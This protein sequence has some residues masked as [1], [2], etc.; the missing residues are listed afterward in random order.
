M[1]FLFTATL[2]FRTLYRSG[3]DFVFNDFQDITSLAFNGVAKTT[4]NKS[5][6]KDSNKWMN[7][8]KENFQE[9]LFYKDDNGAF[10]RETITTYRVNED[11]ET[12]TDFASIAGFGHRDHTAENITE[13]NLPARLRLSPS[14][15]S[16][17]GSVW[18]NEPLHVV[19]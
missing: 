9:L 3:G 11:E 16:T 13:S 15:P 17:A 4:S 12:S 10:V 2:L 1:N 6:P 18:Y 7:D 8:G 19:S 14:Q 5:R